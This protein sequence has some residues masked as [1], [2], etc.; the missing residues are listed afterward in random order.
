MMTPTSEERIEVAERL[1]RQ[2]KYM[3]ENDS[4][5]E[6]VDILG[7]GNT[8]YRNIA[9]A[10]DE[11]SNWEKG[12]Y[13]HI[14]ERL[15][16]LIDPTSTVEL[17]RVVSDKH[18]GNMRWVP[19]CS[20]C[21]SLLDGEVPRYCPNCGSRLVDDSHESGSCACWSASL[22]DEDRRLYDIQVDLADEDAMAAIGSILGRKTGGDAHGNRSAD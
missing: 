19:T 8:A 5:R 1:R 18:C 4:Y 13:V 22:I 20:A 12:L 21:G 17:N 7:C 15:A 11:N 3:R 10:V 9:W 16:D 14:V 6:D 2:L